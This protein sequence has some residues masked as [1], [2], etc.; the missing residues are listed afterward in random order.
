MVNYDLS[1]LRYFGLQ[2]Y[3]MVRIGIWLIQ[4]SSFYTGEGSQRQWLTRLHCRLHHGALDGQSNV[5]NSDVFVLQQCS[6]DEE[7]ALEPMRTSKR[8]FSKIY[9]ANCIPNTPG[10]PLRQGVLQIVPFL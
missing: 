10:Q 9:M 4:S 1:L 2:Q 3:H 8:V 7:H 6:E 5:G